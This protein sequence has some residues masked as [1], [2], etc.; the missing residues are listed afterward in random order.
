MG[1]YM[2]RSIQLKILENTGRDG[3][4]MKALAILTALF[5]PGTFMAVSLFVTSC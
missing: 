5:L 2:D 4:K 1:D 3:S